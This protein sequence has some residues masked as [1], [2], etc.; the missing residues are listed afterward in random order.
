[1][2]T[3]IMEG[4]SMV[5]A[6][7]KPGRRGDDVTGKLDPGLLAAYRATS[8][9]VLPEGIAVRIGAESADLDRLMARL[10]ARSAVF[11][12]AWNPAS[13][14]TDPAENAAAGAALAREV[15]E[16]GW[17]ALPQ[18]G[19]GD[20]GDWPPEPGLLV[21]DLDRAAALDLALRYGQNAVVWCEPGRPAELLLTE[22]AA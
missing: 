4:L 3:R 13:R 22:L 1:L 9:T 18:E 21:L 17:R 11:V 12:T 2:N 6:N 7:R 10:G 20:A 8:Y 15:E 16:R 19:R 5:D 14:P